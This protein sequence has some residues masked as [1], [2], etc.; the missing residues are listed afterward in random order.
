MHFKYLEI[1]MRFCM[2]FVLSSGERH[3]KKKKKI[4]WC[5]LCMLTSLQEYFRGYA[6]DSIPMVREAWNKCT[7]IPLTHFTTNLPF[8]SSPCLARAHSL[9]GYSI[10]SHYHDKT[11]FSLRAKKK[12]TSRERI[13]L[14]MK[15]REMKKWA[16]ITYSLYTYI[17]LCT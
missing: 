15:D 16:Q 9:L 8:S 17:Y 6:D 13:K 3:K 12:K 11:N 4:I 1:Y 14:K 10:F 7:Q 2:I 5:V